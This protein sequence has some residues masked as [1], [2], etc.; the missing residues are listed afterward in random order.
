ML[1]VILAMAIA[2]GVADRSLHRAPLART[3]PLPVSSVSSADVESS[4]WYCLGG[5]SPTGSAAAAALNLVNTTSK[6]AFGTL[7]AVSDTGT[8]KSEPIEIP[9]DTQIVEAP[10]LLVGGAFVAATVDIDGGGVLVNESVAGPLGWSEAAC[11]RSTASAWYFASGSTVNGGTLTVSLYNPTTTD[12]VVDMTFVT[13]SGIAQPEPFEGI[14][15]LPGQLKV[16]HIDA[17]VQDAASVSSIVAVR[18]GAVVAAALQAVSNQGAHGLSLRLGV[19]APSPTWSVPRSIDL[20][21]GLTAITVFN[22]T[23]T[24]EVVRVEV[25]PYRSPAAVFSHTLA[26]HTTWVLSTSAQQ[27]IPEA[28]P[29]LATVRVR[30]GPGVVVDRSIVAPSSFPAPQ[31]GAVSGLAIGPAQAEAQVAMLPSPG[32]PD[33]PAVTNAAVGGVNLVNPGSVPL[34]ATL[35]YLSTRRGLVKLATVTVGPNAARTLGPEQSTGVQKALGLARVG[36][37]PL[38]VSADRPIV[39]LEDLT[40]SATAGI[41]S[42]AGAGATTP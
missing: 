31:F 6:H 15:V 5:T 16:E 40:P 20:T 37:L 13:P 29:F 22:P 39:V 27:R 32:S 34:R 24:K 4:V 3:P 14:Q 7:T 35:S 28:I 19:P 1:F 12:A 10:G 42:F 30:S 2:G 33:D 17:Y 25:H 36:R 18:T 23:T 41:V 11:S 26:G 9:A 8:T 38:V 21:G